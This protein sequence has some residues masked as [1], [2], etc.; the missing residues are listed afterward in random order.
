MVESGF[1]LRG[2]RT[3]VVWVAVDG[4][5]VEKKLVMLTTPL[6]AAY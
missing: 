3:V 2:I 6:A 1:F 5:G 4:G